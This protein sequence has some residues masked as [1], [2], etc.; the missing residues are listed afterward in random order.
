MV[1][2]DAEA[3]IPHHRIPMR[4]GVAGLVLFESQALV[5]M[6]GRDDLFRGQAQFQETSNHQSWPAVR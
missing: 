1:Q 3:T 4:P 2:A 6:D 5:E